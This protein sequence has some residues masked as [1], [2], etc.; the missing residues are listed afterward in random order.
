MA[1]LLALPGAAVAAPNGNGRAT[2]PPGAA[3]SQ[4]GGVPELRREL[5]Q[6]IADRK[7]ADAALAGA[8]R[9]YTDSKVAAEASARA[10]GDAATLSQA[11]AYTDL[12]RVVTRPATA[13]ECPFG[14]TALVSL[15]QVEL[16]C[17]GAPGE[18][19]DPGPA[20]ATGATGATG[21]TG[22]QGP[23]GPAGSGGSLEGATCYLPG[24]VASTYVLTV[25]QD[26]GTA[27]T[28]GPPS[29]LSKYVR[30]YWP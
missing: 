28:C 14:G 26:G 16:A 10:A 23:P 17:N 2:P 18:K 24:G 12:Q 5:D 4:A 22:P 11:N 27:I 3:S 9:A 7:A 1:L 29:A 30:S 8:D 15:A 20:G 21:P 6:E 19:G 13:A 25:G